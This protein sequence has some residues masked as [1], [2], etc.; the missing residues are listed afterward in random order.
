MQL[1]MLILGVANGTTIKILSKLVPFLQYR[2]KM[3]QHLS[4]QHRVS[5]QFREFDGLLQS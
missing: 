4:E 1:C 3:E 2:E 5:Q